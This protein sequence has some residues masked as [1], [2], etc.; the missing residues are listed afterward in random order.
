VRGF[1]LEGEASEEEAGR[2]AFRERPQGAEQLLTGGGAPARL[3]QLAALAESL[4]YIA[5]AII[6]IAGG[7]SR[8]WGGAGLGGRGQGGG[9]R[10]GGEG[11]GEGTSVPV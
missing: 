6:R 11:K 4:D 2:A 10:G 5:N 9:G 1:A 3:V 7:N 8:R